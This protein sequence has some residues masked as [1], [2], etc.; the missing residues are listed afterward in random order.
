MKVKKKIIF[1]CFVFFLLVLGLNIHSKEEKDKKKKNT[2]LIVIPVVS[3]TPETRF[4]GGAAAGFYFRPEKASKEIR[5]S[6]VET[7]HQYTQNKQIY[8]YFGLSL[9]LREELYH[10]LGIFEYRKWPNYFYGIGNDTL[11]EAEE[12]YTPLMSR[13]D[14]NLEKRLK[15]NLYLGLRYRYMNH[16]IKEVLPGGIL[17]SG[18]IIGSEDSKASGFGAAFVLDTRDNIF[19]PYTG[20]FYEFS[21]ISY[22][23]L[24]GSDYSFTSVLINLRNYW[25]VF[26]S[27]VIAVQAY[28][29]SNF[30][31]P[32][33][34]MLS[35]MGG[36]E[37]M[38][39]YYRGRFRDKN[40]LA[41]QFE[42]RLP[43]TKRFRFI[44]FA[45]LGNVSEDLFDIKFKK[46]KYSVGIGLRYTIS[47][48][49][50][51]CLRMD[52]GTGKG[53]SG[54]YF[55]VNEAF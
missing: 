25:K 16:K 2:K 12:I 37:L 42:Y 4:G 34:Y 30:G 5:P 27:H 44:T 7:L 52:Y 53:T 22:N 55:G 31:D 43:L 50:R 10:F 24:F 54:Y 1:C 19:S 21:I 40:L 51:L 32:P 36:Q 39:G 20:R 46:S 38:R 47:P 17:S 23:A 41:F 8:S 49:E 33:F 28:L 11:K 29:S 48:K 18:N 15:K 9:Y 14:I 6:S 45:G 26:S 35:L 13:I 3:Y